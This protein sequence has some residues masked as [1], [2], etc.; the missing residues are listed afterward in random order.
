MAAN[1][2]YGDFRPQP[3]QSQ[4]PSY[5]HDDYNN[6]SP[7]ESSHQLHAFPSTTSQ[8]PYSSGPDNYGHHAQYS[9]N[10]F[11]DDSPFVG[12]RNHPADQYGEDI[13]LKPNAQ[14]PQPPDSHWMNDNTNYDA[15]MPMDPVMGSRKRRRRTQRWGFFGKRTPWVTWL[16]TVVDIGVFIGE[17]IYSGKHTCSILRKRTM[18][19]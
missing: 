5:H 4:P 11:I 7:A 2:Y 13:P 6:K 1:D 16:L 12:G 10:S 14:P 8:T 15:G 17:L 19:S 9:Q 18:R 3:S